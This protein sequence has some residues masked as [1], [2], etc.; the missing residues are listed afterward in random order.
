MY[1]LTKIEDTVRIPPYKFEDPLEEVAIE[2]LNETYNGRL[3]K[4][5][6]L[7]VSVNNI[8]VI[9]EGKV[10]MGD[11]AAYHEVVFN[12]VFFKPELYEIING[13]V[14]E[15]AEFGAFI[16]IGPMDGL[17]HVSQVTDD[18]INYDSKRGALLAK[19]SKKTLEEGNFV[20][21]R[22]VAVSLKG[23]STKETRIGLTMRQPNLGRFEWIEDEKNKSKK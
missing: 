19:E 5:L 14:I 8:E 15:I 13:E 6:G 18:Y 21:A 12:A 22:I 20:R 16:R 7:L 9:G 23:K 2:T 3:D 10:I 4:K 11:G 17:V 1:Y